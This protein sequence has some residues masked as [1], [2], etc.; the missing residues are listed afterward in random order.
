MEINYMGMEMIAKI[1]NVDIL[2]KE[3]SKKLKVRSNG[4]IQNLIKLD[5]RFLFQITMR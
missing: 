1:N 5:I 2:K 4:T 3:N